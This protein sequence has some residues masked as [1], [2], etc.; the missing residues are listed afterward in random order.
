MDKPTSSNAS[1][2]GIGMVLAAAVLWGTTGTAQS[3]GPAGLSAYWVG[4]LRLAVAAAFF[5]AFT[6]WQQPRGGSLQAD[7]RRMPWRW[8]LLAGV[9][10][11]AY[12]LSFF[13]GVKA[14][15]VAVGTAIAIGS[16]PIWAGLL[17]TAVSRRPPRWDWW[18]GTLLAVAGGCLM[19]MGG[20]QQLQV[21]PAGVALCLV[22]GLSYACYALVNKRLV[23]GMSAS[24]V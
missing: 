4:A 14:T 10:I 24:T 13:A 17:Q 23:T 11:A 1:S 5:A 8:V 6:L 19:V 9:G 2:L 12:N 15:G 22:A 18:L 3:L 7:L 16:G 21:T 20:A